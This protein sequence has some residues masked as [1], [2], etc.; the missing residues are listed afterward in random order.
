MEYF[1]RVECS[2]CGSEYYVP[3]YKLP[4]DRAMILE[5]AFPSLCPFCEDGNYAILSVS[6]EAKQKRQ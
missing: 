3:E 1:V 5:A 2:S 4:E 6:K